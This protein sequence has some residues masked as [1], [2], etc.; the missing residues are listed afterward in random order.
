MRWRDW[1]RPLDVGPLR[2]R[3]PWEP[4]RP[5]ALDVVIDPGQAFGTGAHPRPGSRS[6]CSSSCAPRRRARR[7]GL[8][9]RH[10]RGR[11]RAAGLRPGAG[12]RRRARVGRR[13]AGGG[14]RATASPIAVARC[15][16]RREAGP[17]APTVTANLVRPL[18][19]EVAARIER[20]PER[21]IASGL[22]AGEADEVVAGV[23]PPRARAGGAPRRRRLVRHPADP[24]ISLDDV[25]AAA[26]RIER[27]G[28]PH[29]GAHLARA[30][31]GDRRDRC[32]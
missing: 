19:L 6:S 29:A 8:R 16:L 32:S 3:P 7:L 11:R 4:A 31:R 27:R 13:D 22:E 1:H 30:R 9:L 28:A 2:V 5:G 24:M 18:L 17:W 12:V 15:D 26:G 23:R 14:R 10:P 25:R 21:L 20:P